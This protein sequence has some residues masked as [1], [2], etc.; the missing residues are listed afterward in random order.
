MQSI[1]NILNNLINRIR[2]FQTY[3]RPKRSYENKLFIQSLQNLIKNMACD[4]KKEI[5][6]LHKEFDPASIPYQH[7]LSIKEIMIQLI[8]NAIYHGIECPD[9]RLSLNKSSFGSIEISS[10]VNNNTLE[11]K[12]RDNGRGLQI[13]KLRQK[14]KIYGKWKKIEIDKWDD[15]KVAET[16][17]FSGISTSENANFMAGRGGGM[18]IVKEKVYKLAGKIEVSFE[19]GQF[20]EFIITLSLNNDSQ[21]MPENSSMDI[22]SRKKSDIEIEV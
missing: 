13:E 4:L 10:F 15:K 16:I 8:R 17:F 2:N 1:L 9:E 22:L 3:F 11:L 6:F 21:V 18:D 14:A 5:K 20:C 12:F 7:R 19:S